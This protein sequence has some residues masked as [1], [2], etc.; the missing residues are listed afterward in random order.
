MLELKE[1]KKFT[2]GVLYVRNLPKLT[3]EVI[4][5]VD[6]VDK[7]VWCFFVANSLFKRIVTIGANVHVDMIWR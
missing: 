5:K 3:N 1:R 7:V 6:K 4:N 2:D